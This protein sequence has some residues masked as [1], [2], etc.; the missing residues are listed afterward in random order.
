[1]AA[2]DSDRLTP[3]AIWQG[4]GHDWLSVWGTE[5]AGKRWAQ[6][7][8]DRRAK[9]NSYLHPSCK[10]EITKSEITQTPSTASNAQTT[11]AQTTAPFVLIAEADPIDFLA[12]FLAAALEGWNIVLANPH[13]GSQEWTSLAQLISPQLIW[14]PLVPIQAIANQ[15][16]PSSL[17]GHNPTIL[18]PT[19]GS[20]G[21][22]KLAYHTWSS[23][24]TAVTGFRQHFAAAYSVDRPIHTYCVLPLHHVS[25]LMQI[26][27]AWASNTDVTITPFKQLET[28][29]TLTPQLRHQ[30]GFISLVPTQLQRLIQAGKAQ[31]L[32]TFQAVFLGGAPPWQ[33]LLTLAKAHRIPL[34][35]SYGMTETGAMVTATSQQFFLAHEGPHGSG[36]AM[37]HASIK[38]INPVQA[39]NESLLPESLSPGSLGQI[40][41]CSRAIA[42][43]YYPPDTDHQRSSAFAPNTFYTDDLGYLSDDGQLH[44]TGR[45]SGKIISGGENIFPAE[46][47][48]A[49][50]STGQVS[51]VCVVGFPHEQW[52]E[53]VT[54]IYVPTHHD[55]SPE[56]L[57]HALTQPAEDTNI[58]TLSRYKQPK[59]WFAVATLPR[60][61]QGKLNRS[62]LLRQLAQLSNPPVQPS[63]DG[64]DA[65]GY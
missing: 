17:P 46:V 23:L 18:I 32:S 34:V 21:D 64:A 56:T 63:T 1:M 35:L 9:L 58:P 31:W 5:A 49:L 24:M 27:R 39:Q 54:A 11:K 51:D 61:A 15:K 55:V 62:Q 43:G 41:V 52:G 36:R 45:A 2:L 60:N 20:S 3:Q 4:L 6:Q 14:G 53:A 40:V 29:P 42:Q 65:F 37:P 30:N 59:Q 26:L 8:C 16:T 50:R 48:A 10:S 12:G 38:I 33:S 47:E 7:V 19:G 25:G 44:I 57:K 13:W 22:V 28:A